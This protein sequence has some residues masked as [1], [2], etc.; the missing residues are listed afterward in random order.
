[1][2][3]PNFG[4]I[5][6]RLEHLGVSTEVTYYVLALGAQDSETGQYAQGFAPSTIDMILVQHEPTFVVLPS[7]VDSQNVATGYTDTQVFEGDRIE[8]ADGLDYVVNTVIEHAFG[9]QTIY[10]ECELALLFPYTQSD[11]THMYPAPP[12]GSCTSLAALGTE[13]SN[14][15]ISS[16]VMG[17]TNDNMPITISISVIGVVT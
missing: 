10:Y 7:G 4:Q 11:V 5:R 12:S 16:S 13:F 3:V 6:R 9:D 17:E 14:P 8:D 15:E 1:L 2:S